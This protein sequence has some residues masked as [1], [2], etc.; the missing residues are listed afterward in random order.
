M[1]NNER[2]INEIEYNPLTTQNL[3]TQLVTLENIR[4]I[5]IENPIFTDLYVFS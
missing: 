5:N 3:A 2:Q 4:D 1:T